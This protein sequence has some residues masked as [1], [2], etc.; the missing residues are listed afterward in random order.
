M[1]STRQIDGGYRLAREKFDGS[2]C[3]TEG[4]SG[5]RACATRH[6][7]QTARPF[8][9]GQRGRGRTGRMDE[10][11]PRFVDDI[12]RA[13]CGWPMQ[14]SGDAGALVITFVPHARTHGLGRNL[15]RSRR[16]AVAS[17]WI[18]AWLGQASRTKLRHV[19]SCCGGD[20]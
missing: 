11:R 9:S 12:W 18:R 20:L 5:E 16:C 6:G 14:W 17:T 15:L 1:R 3:C 19:E 10:S 8:F 4:F 13:V 7:Y 2:M